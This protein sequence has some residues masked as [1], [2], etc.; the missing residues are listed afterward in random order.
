M[1][2]ISADSFELSSQLHIVKMD[3][4]HL[5]CWLSMDALVLK[6]LAWHLDGLLPTSKACTH[7][8]GHGGLKQTVRQVY[9]ALPQYHFVCKTDVKGY[10]E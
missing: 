7:L 4:N 3:G 5:H 6:L 10:Y 9:D 2:L 8:K 1:H